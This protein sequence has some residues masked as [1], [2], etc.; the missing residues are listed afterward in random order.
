[1]ETTIHQKHYKQIVKLAEISPIVSRCLWL[2]NSGEMT[3]EEMLMMAVGNLV[4]DNEALQAV[5][6]DIFERS[7]QPIIVHLKNP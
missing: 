6:Q 7:V 4:E 3:W 1:M 2:Y 5:L